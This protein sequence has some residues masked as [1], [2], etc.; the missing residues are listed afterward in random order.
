MTSATKEYFTY[1]PRSARSEACP[2]ISWP[3]GTC[4]NFPPPLANCTMYHP[5]AIAVNTKTTWSHHHILSVLLQ[6]AINARVKDV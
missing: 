4:A 3:P 5:I 6:S 1:L 2:E